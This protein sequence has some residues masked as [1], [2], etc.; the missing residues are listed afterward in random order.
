MSKE[1]KETPVEETAENNEQEEAAEGTYSR[2]FEEWERS[3]V[4]DPGASFFFKMLSGMSTEFQDEMSEQT[5]QLF[6]FADKFKESMQHVM[7][8]PEGRDL[9]KKELKSRIGKS[10]GI[11]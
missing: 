4:K 3:K 1:D 7:S 2:A 5:R 6:A 10:K 11:K 9:L 8:E